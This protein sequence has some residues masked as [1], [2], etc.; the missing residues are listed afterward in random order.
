MC[1]GR[2]LLNYFHSKAQYIR[3]LDYMGELVTI[4]C[5]EENLNKIK[6]EYGDL[7]RAVWKGSEFE[8]GS[9]NHSEEQLLEFFLSTP[10]I[11]DLEKERCLVFEGKLY[12]SD[13]NSEVKAIAKK[14]NTDVY[15]LNIKMEEATGVLW[16]ILLKQ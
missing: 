15:N 2:T 1:N 13:I 9:D 5:S 8:F 14:L 4:E 3:I 12:V 6:E 10:T 16:G 7:Y 11:I